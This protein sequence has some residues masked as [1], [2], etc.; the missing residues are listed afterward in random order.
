ME[1]NRKIK[2]WM[3]C[4][5][6]L[7]PLIAYG[8]TKQEMHCSG[9]EPFWG[10]TMK[11]G[12]VVFTQMDQADVSLEILRRGTFYGQSEGAGFVMRTLTQDKAK[13]KINFYLVN[14]KGCSDGMSER[15]Y[16][17]YILADINQ[18]QIF[19]G[20]CNVGAEIA[21]TYQ[22]DK[23]GAGDN[24][25]V[26]KGPGVSHPIIGK[27]AHDAVGIKKEHCLNDWCYVT[28]QAHAKEVLSGWVNQ[29][30]LKVTAK[31]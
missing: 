26:R 13:K 30:F 23:V 6:L 31:P 11:G 18:E 4:V 20:C 9:T 21:D 1:W 22:V 15:V 28:R 8:E 3:L 29:K 27:L 16:N 5:S 24:L 14:A 17:S 10:L 25:N 19:Y 7:A 2:L 12:L